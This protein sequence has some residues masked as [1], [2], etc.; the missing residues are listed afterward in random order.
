MTHWL[1]EP[2]GWLDTL[3]GLEDFHYPGTRRLLELPPGPP[4]VVHAHNLHGKYFDLRALPELSRQVPFILTLHDAWLM[5]GH[6][7]HSF[8][9]QRWRTG[10]GAC[11]DLSIYPGIR[12]DATALNWRRKREIL[13]ASRLHVAVPCRWLLGLV[14]AAFPVSGIA[15]SRII[16]YGVDLS[17][18]RPQ[19]RARV[20][21]DLQIPEDA[22]VLLF[23]ANGIRNNVWKDYGTMRA[24]LG[25][26][27]A[28]S[29]RRKLL[30][31][32]LGETA[33]DERVGSGE[34]RFVP[35]QRDPA[36]VARYYCAADLY[37]H[38]ARADTFPNA[39]L[40][41]LACGT[42]VVATAV[43]GI[44]EQ[45]KSLPRDGS[46]AGAALKS[47]GAGGATGVL[48]ECGDPEALAGA[49][50]RLL[51]DPVLRRGLAENAVEEARRRFSLSREADDY[52]NWYGELAGGDR[53]DVGR[54]AVAGLA[55]VGG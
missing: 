21:A 34:L 52:L 13:A 3:R 22:D 5:T 55:H 40:E 26:H 8:E 41:A 7:A 32:A 4:D 17:V 42:P 10:C 33:P 23:A 44:P 19:E 28:R 51:S 48:V 25:T 15:E 14:E 29:P 46:D 30:F 54:Q 31:L 11:P 20:R 47:W 27:P 12:R 49:V 9:C 16:P 2:R 35:Y 45:V 36:W 37:V 6:C 24:A 39:V 38:A 53:P 50:G 1:A 43:G 18:F